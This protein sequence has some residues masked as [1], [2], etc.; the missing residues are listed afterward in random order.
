MWDQPHFRYVVEARGQWD[1]LRHFELLVPGTLAWGL[2]TY[3]NRQGDLKS[4]RLRV[5]R[6]VPQDLED[7]SSC[8]LFVPLHGAWLVEQ[9]LQR[10][11]MEY[12][13]SSVRTG[14]V[15]PWPT[16]GGRES[17]EH[18]G[19]R[20]TTAAVNRGE[21][22]SHVIDLA[23]RY[24]FAS[25]GWATGRPWV[26]N[27]WSC[28]SGKTLGAILGSFTRA[29]PVLVV[30]PAKA[31]HVW[32]ES[33]SPRS[34]SSMRSTLMVA[35]RGGRLFKRLMAPSLSTGARPLPVSASTLRWTRRTGR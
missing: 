12:E 18:N 4:R 23:T 8:E 9:E 5:E 29:G 14:G 30:A 21:L 26:M 31:R 6:S 10:A 16:S 19:R 34:L 32:C 22:R 1:F 3:V 25:A 33:C 27:V 2:R 7:L 11:H 35:T 24:Q 20:L 17:L 28:G 15:T 13:Y